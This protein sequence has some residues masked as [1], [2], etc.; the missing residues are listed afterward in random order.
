MCKYNPASG[1]SDAYLEKDAGGAGAG[2]KTSRVG[3]GVACTVAGAVV[4]ALGFAVLRDGGV[5]GDNVG[6]RGGGGGGGQ[7]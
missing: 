3:L 4:L 5:G 7:V 1:K 2:G 6:G